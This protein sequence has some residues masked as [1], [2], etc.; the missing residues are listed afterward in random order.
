MTDYAI[1]AVG[2]TSGNERLIGTAYGNEAV[3]FEKISSRE[4]N[5]I[6]DTDPSSSDQIRIIQ[7]A[8]NPNAQQKTAIA[9]WNDFT[10][11]LMEKLNGIQNDWNQ[12]MDE[13]LNSD[14]TKLEI[15]QNADMSPTASMESHLRGLQ[16]TLRS[17][18]HIQRA[19]TG[20]QLKIALVTTVGS[21]VKTSISTL[22]RQQG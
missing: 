21:T 11:R 5:S 1:S 19:L 9:P 14:F 20:S 22:Y 12:N 15:S 6:W 4:Q 3:E 10:A 18:L 13:L 7:E 16:S 17:S 2:R 8:S